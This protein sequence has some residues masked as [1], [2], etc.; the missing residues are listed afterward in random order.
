MARHAP[1]PDAMLK[2]Y[3]KISLRNLKKNKGYAFINIFGLAIG[4]A[5]C[6][7]IVLFVR[8]E[9]SYD[10]FH[11]NAERTH[12]IVRQS[13][14][15]APSVTVSVPLAP[16]LM[17]TF[18]E[19]QHATRLFHYWFTPLIS[20]G[21]E[22][23]YEEHTYF[24]DSLFFEVFDFSLARGNPAT[25]LREPFSILLTETM[26]RKY[27]GDEDPV[28]QTLMMNAAHAFT[29]T[30]ILEDPPRTSHFTF[31]FLAAIESLPAVM[32]WPNVM[33][34]W[35]LGAF[36]TYVVLP[37]GYDPAL[38][39]ENLAAYKP[40]EL[41][42]R[43]FL[44]PLKGIHLHSKYRGEIEPGSDVRYVWL[45]SGIALI[46]LLLACINY[47]NLATA[48]FA[49]RTR[50][51][52]IRKVV[53]A[54]RRQLMG[55][56]L[57]ES[58]FLSMVALLVALALLEGLLLAFSTLIDGALTF[59][60]TEDYGML[61]AIVGIALLA[62]LVAGSYPAFYLSAFR[63]GAVLKGTARGVRRTPLRRVLVVTQYAIA[64]V[65]LAGAGI[66]YQQLDYMR[67]AGLGFEKEHLV[68]IPV[69]DEAVRAQPD[70]AKAAFSTLPEVMSVSSSTSLPGTKMSG[71]SDARR[72]GAV[73][74]EPF[75]INVGWID[76]D[77]VETLSIS[78][79]AGRGF[80]D[81][82]PTDK[83]ETLLLNETAAR[84]FGWASAAEAVG[85]VIALW[86]EQRRVIG[87]M[88]DFHFESLRS[89][90]GPLLF[91]PEMDEGSGLVL[92]LRTN[93]LRA[94][95]ARLETAW[96]GLSTA[97][98]FTYSFLDEDLESLYVAETRWGQIIGSA[99]LFALL[100]AC[101]GLFGLAS[102]LAEQ[103][104]KEIG[105]RKALGASAPQI[106]A[107]L[108]G[109]FARLV[110]VAFVVSTPVAYFAANRWLD[111]F[112]YRVEMSWGIFLVA[113]LT[114]LGVALLAVSYQSVR[115]ALADPVK[116]LRYE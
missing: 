64:V 36:H 50:E 96:H 19:V 115:A 20:R 82:F 109:D 81:Q 33:E 116:A 30:G 40:S 15:L 95:M 91:F 28:G 94:T 112:A 45:L 79:A 113:G 6:L 80:S 75:R 12:R 84:D 83:D 51:V 87:V 70:V 57:G 3:F 68:V 102:F 89:A 49:R 65:L 73:D 21:E 24:T 58:V 103:R 1:T 88:E 101:L 67:T 53:G 71:T 23:F 100:I 8:D 66:I 52:G 93:D 90:I 74:D 27:F 37:E 47:T 26:A 72:L 41:T 10:R 48:R 86:G 22:G 104:T 111:S 105:V 16:A 59:D 98:P 85:E 5:C 9:L 42:V 108:S 31:D 11:E 107:L 78:M 38:L 46:I 43:Y 7:L 106:A 25:A 44:Q 29:V 92:R 39:D 4:L 35:G 61:A 34:N 60:I 32:D 54:H 77:F 14:D 13:G 97:Q 18:P 114:A 2:N 63:P 76:E 56:F 99:A 17:N 69:R 62:G 55:Q 110:M